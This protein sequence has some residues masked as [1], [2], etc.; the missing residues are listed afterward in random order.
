MCVLMHRRPKELV[1]LLQFVDE[2]TGSDRALV[3]RVSADVE[4]K[5]AQRR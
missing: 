3:G 1:E 5:R 2:G 4:V